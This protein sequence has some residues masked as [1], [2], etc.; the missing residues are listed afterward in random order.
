M[1][2]VRFRWRIV[3]A[4]ARVRLF[5]GNAPDGWTDEGSLAKC[6]EFTFGV[7]DWIKISERLARVGDDEVVV[8]IKHEDEL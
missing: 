7:D 5:V 6:G 8:Q 4:H 2:I 3:G 1:L